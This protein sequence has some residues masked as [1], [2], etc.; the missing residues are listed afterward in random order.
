MYRTAPGFIHRKIA[1]SDVLVSM[2]VAAFNGYIALNE[3]CAFLWDLM[4]TPQSAAQLA[5]KLTETYDVPYDQAL[6]D[7]TALLQ[8]MI[9]RGV[10]QEVAE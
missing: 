10:V 6:T 9:D 4:A 7:V 2:N 8:T 1:N 5:Q 3:T